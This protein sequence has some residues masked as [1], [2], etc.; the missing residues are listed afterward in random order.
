MI[1][2]D[3]N[4]GKVVAAEGAKMNPRFAR[5]LANRRTPMRF[6]SDAS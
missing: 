3:A 1:L 5:K 2:V 6:S 4:T